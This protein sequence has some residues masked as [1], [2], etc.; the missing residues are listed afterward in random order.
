MFNVSPFYLFGLVV[1][2][3]PHEAS[4]GVERSGGPDADGCRL[5]S[6]T[7]LS[8]NDSEQNYCFKRIHW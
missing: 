2:T 8:D 6:V 5:C 7:L 1:F 4:E 3:F